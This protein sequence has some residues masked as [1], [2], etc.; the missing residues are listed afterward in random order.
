VS[1]DSELEDEPDG[2]LEEQLEELLKEGDAEDKAAKDR[3]LLL[4]LIG[5]EIRTHYN[6]GGIV[7]NIHGPHNAYGP[8]SWTINYTEDGKKRKNPCIINSIKVEDGVITC[9]G[10]PLQIVEHQE[11]QIYIYRGLV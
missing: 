9:E 2:D 11:E 4:T 3:E 1:C 8:D 7:T 5:K 10:K 6:T